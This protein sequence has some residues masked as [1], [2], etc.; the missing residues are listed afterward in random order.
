MDGRAVG[1]IWTKIKPLNRNNKER[2]GYP[3]Q[4]PM[5]LLERIIRASSNEGDTVMDPF[6]GSGTALLAA[7]RL[8]RKWIGID[9]SEEAVKLSRSRLNAVLI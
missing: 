2:T 1:S 9:L 5:A 8:G 4:K 7:K 6:C 3:T